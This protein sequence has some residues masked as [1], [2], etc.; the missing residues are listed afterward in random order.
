V[1]TFLI[2][3]LLTVL[4]LWLVF[5]HFDMERIRRHFHSENATIIF[6]R[7][8]PFS[9]GWSLDKLQFGDGNRIYEARYQDTNGNLRHVWCKTC[10]LN[11]VTLQ[12]D[13]LS[14]PSR[15]V[16]QT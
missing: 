5:I 12:Q 3:F 1:T 9:H 13:E 15:P 7:W 8:C 10:L 6:I 14:M 4:A 16:Q 11:G 2:L